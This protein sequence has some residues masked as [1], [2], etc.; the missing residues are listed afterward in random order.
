MGDFTIHLDDWTGVEATGVFPITQRHPPLP[1]DFDQIKSNSSTHLALVNGCKY[2]KFIK[3]VVEAEQKRK[4]N[5]EYS[6]K[7][8]GAWFSSSLIE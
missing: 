3:Q 6:G 5:T 8:R 2:A 4:E 1:S 7:S